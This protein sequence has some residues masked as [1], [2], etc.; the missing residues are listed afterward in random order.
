MVAS[1]EVYD[2]YDLPEIIRLSGCDDIKTARVEMNRLFVPSVTQERL[3]FAVKSYNHAG[4]IAREANKARWLEISE[5]L[6]QID[7]ESVRPLRAKLAGSA[8]KDDDDKLA[9][10]DLEAEELRKDLMDSST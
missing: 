6:A 3:D 1:V 9:A 4:F 5:R 8:T 10:L 2:G 7:A